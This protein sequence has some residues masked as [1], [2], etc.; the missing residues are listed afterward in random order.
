MILLNLLQMSL[1]LL[2]LR[3]ELLLFCANR[4]DLFTQRSNLSMVGLF[5]CFPGRSTVAKLICGLSG[6]GFRFLHG[7]FHGGYL[8]LHFVHCLR[9]IRLG[10]LKFLGGGRLRLCQFLHL[11]CMHLLGLLLLLSHLLLLRCESVLFTLSLCQFFFKRQNLGRAGLGGGLLG[12]RG[13]FTGRLGLAMRFGHCSFERLHL[14]S[15]LRN[16]L[17]VLSFSRFQFGRMRLRHF[18][19]L[20]LML[21]LS[22]L[23]SES[24]VLLTRLQVAL[25]LAQ[26]IYLLLERLPLSIA[27]LG[28]VGLG[29][30]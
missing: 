23:Q 28:R 10:G 2:L 20:G 7:R 4:I 8:L 12:G 30:L 6:L 14:L 27:G 16:C 29:L 24:Q 1:H 11:S 22:L 21:F 18:F 17:G 26:D 9:V 15:R 25:F 13:L 3:F 19:Q 5:R